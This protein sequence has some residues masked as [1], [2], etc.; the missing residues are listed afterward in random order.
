MKK[1]LISTAMPLALIVALLTLAVDAAA[2]QTDDGIQWFSYAEGRQR[3]ETESKKVFLFFNSD[4]C[5]YCAQMEKETFRNPTVI[6][7][8]NRNFIPISVNSDKDQAI[9][10]KYKVQGLPNT[11]FIS[12]TGDPIANRPGYIAPDEMLKILKFI[13]TDSYRSM[14]FKTFMEK[15]Q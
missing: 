13:G 6:A 11:F 1:R 15:G 3:G 14:S 5:R 8:V 4:W 9:A 10:A 12:E 2:A 7:Y